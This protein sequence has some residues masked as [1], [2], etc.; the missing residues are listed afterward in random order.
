MSNNSSAFDDQGSGTEARASNT[1]G[2]WY[3]SNADQL[4]KRF[5]SIRFEQLHCEVLEQIPRKPCFILDIGAGSGR[6]ASALAQLGHYVTAVEPSDELRCRAQ[7]AHHHPNIQ[8]TK[9]SLPKLSQVRQRGA[10]YDVIFLSAVWMH[11]AESQ[12]ADAFRRITNMLKPGGLLYITLRHGPFEEIPGFWDIPPD[13][14]M[15]LARENGLLPVG[16]VGKKQDISKRPGV[17]WSVLML[18]APGDGTGALPLLRQIILNDDKSSTYKL[19]LLK[20]L[21]HIAQSASGL[22]DIQDDEK[23]VIPLGLFALYWLR[24]YR[25]LL[26]NNMPQTPQNTHSTVGLGFVNK[27]SAA[28]DI[29]AK[30]SPHDLRIGMKFEA[31]TAKAL[32]ATLKTICTTLVKMPMKYITFGN[33]GDK[34]FKATARSQFSVPDPVT[35]DREYFESFGQVTISAN[36]WQTMHHYG[37]WIEPAIVAEWKQLMQKYFK[38]QQKSHASI[39]NME[40]A[41][42][43]HDPERGTKRSRT[44]AFEL[45]QSGQFGNCVWSRKKITTESFDIDHCFPYSAWPCAD[46]WNL[47]PASRNVNQNQKRDKLPKAELLLKSKDLILE[48]WDKAYVGKAQDFQ[49]DFFT[50][51]DASL[52]IHSAGSADG[53][54]RLEDVFTALV[55]QQQNLRIHQQIPE[56]TT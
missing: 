20:V 14:V 2:G 51:A 32:N 41:L 16:R 55:F 13:E 33:S 56:W 10:L 38:S 36:L 34:V 35:L 40:A 30:V 12:R 24:V 49:E 5:E 23:V 44:R 25:P 43:W 22:V 45:I 37:S 7:R 11:V 53:S 27:K 15:T 48:W 6:D 52:R 21:A 28:Y 26:D 1:I 46:L 31:E 9:D 42:V 8:W 18:R 47:M 3:D 54:N 4:F 17:S 19:G 29:V 39:E 50:Q